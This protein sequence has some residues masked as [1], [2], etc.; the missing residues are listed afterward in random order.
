MLLQVAFHARLAQERP[1][2]ERFSIDE[3]AADS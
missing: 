3:V 1:A 2:G